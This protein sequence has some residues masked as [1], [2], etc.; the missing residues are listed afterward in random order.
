LAAQ[1]EHGGSKAEAG[2]LLEPGSVAETLLWTL[3]HRASEA[4]RP[5]GVIRDPKAVELLDRIDF[6]FEER[7]GA[8]SAGWAQWQALRALCFDRQVERFLSDQ[9]DGTV[10]ALGEGL[11]TQFWRVDNGRVRWLSVDLPEAIELRRTLLPPPARQRLLG[12]SALD[13]RW[14]D[15]VGADCGVMV[16]AQGLLMY[17][18]PEEVHRLLGACASRIREGALLFD[19]VPR[20]LSERSRRGELVGAGGYRPPPWTWGIDRE[21]KRRILAQPTI[22][23]LRALPLPRGRGLL[24]GFVVPA[25]SRLEQIREAL[26]SIMLARVRAARSTA[27]PESDQEQRLF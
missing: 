9:P 6:P 19:A 27:P 10:V 4:R 17:L 22:V 20:W 8:A 16:T 21:E 23:D 12:C 26:L 14:L 15:E 11:E 2:L 25:L 1:E 5:D 3:Y 18:Q 13:E 24:F 7:F